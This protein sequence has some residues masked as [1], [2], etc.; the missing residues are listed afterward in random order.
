MRKTILALAAISFGLGLA[1][2]GAQQ[3]NGESVYLEHCAGCHDTPIPPAPTRAELAAFAPETI[4]NALSTFAMRII[5]E[6]MTHAERRAASEF[7]AGAPAGSLPAPLSL[8][9]ASAY[10]SANPN[11]ADPLAGPAWNGWSPGLANSRMQS[12]EAA[13]LTRA[14]VRALELKWAF[15]IPGVSSSGSQVTVIGNRVFVGSRNGMLWSLD[16]DTGCIAWVFEADGGIRSTPVLDTDNGQLFFGDA[17]AQVYA[18]DALSGELN[19]KLK[20]EDHAVAMITGGTTYYDG[21]VYVPVSSIEEVPAGMPAYECCTFRGSLVALAA[22]DG[23]LRWKTRT[24]QRGPEPTGENSVGTR[25]WGPS[26]AAIWSAPAIDAVRGRIYATTGDNYTHPATPASDAVM[27][28]DLAS[29]EVLWT[30]QTLPDD[31]WNVS[32]LSA[33][34]AQFNCPEDQGPDFD[35][36]SSPALVTRA[37]GSQILLA[38]QKSGVLYGLDPDDG[39]LLWQSRVGD[40]GVLGGIEW[41]FASDGVLAYVAVSEA[42]EKL[43]GDAGGLS[44]I[45]LTNGRIVWEAA[46]SRDSCSNRIGCNSAQ[47]AAVSVIPGVVFSGSVDGHLRAY[48]ADNGAVLWDFDTVR[49]F[50]TVNGVPAYGGSM[51]G[52]GPAVAGGMVFIT[53]GYAS[54]GLM[55]GNVLLAFGARD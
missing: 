23:G 27:A 16:K 2:T 50:D 33:A 4:E 3:L 52:P 17:F 34:D 48:D 14:G 41:G 8:V 21:T 11:V 12:S 26:G 1:P 45:D 38:G 25:T 29:G 35:F 10:C 24:I 32:C 6:G 15:G 51:N 9:P 47:P 44:A 55:P 28:F 53:P 5:G 42:F 36:G 20:I 30:Q 43:A 46:P 39:E 31:V 13:G 37:D 49:Q 18:L 7:A 40:G 54:F 22:D 19:W